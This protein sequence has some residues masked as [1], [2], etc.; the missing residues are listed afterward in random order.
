MTKPKPP[1]IRPPPDYERLVIAAR[2]KDAIARRVPVDEKRAF[3]VQEVCDRVFDRLGEDGDAS[4]LYQRLGGVT[5]RGNPV[6]RTP[7]TVEE[8]GKL[9]RFYGAPRGW[10]LVDWKD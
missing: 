9:A 10:P 6:P 8:L 1:P 2:V 7:F 3:S 5:A 4:W